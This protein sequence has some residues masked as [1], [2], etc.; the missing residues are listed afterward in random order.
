M[1]SDSYM[2]DIAIS[3]LRLTGERFAL[4][5]EPPKGGLNIG[6]EVSNTH[7]TN[8]RNDEEKGYMVQATVGVH[9]TLTEPD[10]GATRVD[11]SVDTF[12]VAMMPQGITGE[13]ESFR[14]LRVEAV[15]AGYE[16]GRARIAELAALSP[17][18]HL[19]LP[20][21]DPDKVVARISADDTPD[22]MRVGG[23][24]LNV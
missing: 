8:A 3:D 6:I 24:V 20:A 13:E 7:T 22:T 11:A 2:S 15:R 14:R 10:D 4:S 21:V 12:V 1:P 23:N 9:V 17:L 5:E 19:N 18:Q 16:F